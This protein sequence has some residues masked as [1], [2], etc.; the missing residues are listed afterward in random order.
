[1]VGHLASLAG[2]DSAAV[3]G[4]DILTVDTAAP[5][6]FGLDGSLFASARLDN[7]SSV[8]AGLVAHLAAEPTDAIAVLAAF[9]HEEIG[10]ESRS[11]ASGP[12]LADV[13]ERITATLGGG[14]VELARAI[15]GSW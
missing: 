12:L 11:G 10:S 4:Y 9:D 6:R 1:M 3:A 13:L 15:A 8:H 14:R 2:I 5:A 7:L